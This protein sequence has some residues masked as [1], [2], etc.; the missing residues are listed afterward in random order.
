[1]QSW[2]KAEGQLDCEEGSLPERKWAGAVAA[3]RGHA[4]GNTEV[5]TLGGCVNKKKVFGGWLGYMSDVS[6]SST[7]RKLY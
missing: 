1:M 2:S 6:G 7:T 5:G 3:G 4:P